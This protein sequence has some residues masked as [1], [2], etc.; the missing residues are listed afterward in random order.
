MTINLPR[1]PLCNILKHTWRVPLDLFPQ[2]VLPSESKLSRKENT[3]SFEIYR[4]TFLD[5]F[6]IFELIMLRNY[7]Q[8]LFLV[9]ENRPKKVKS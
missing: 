2:N 5:D 7:L 4:N 1:A 3:V 8:F 9:L 6:S